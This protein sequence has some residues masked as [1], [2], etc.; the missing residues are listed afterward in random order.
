MICPVPGV[1]T[2]VLQGCP[3]SSEDRSETRSSH[4]SP[5]PSATLSRIFSSSFSCFSLADSFRAVGRVRKTVRR[6]QSLPKAT[7]PYRQPLP[8]LP[9]SL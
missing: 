1:N 3:D 4:H 2:Q 5:L 8:Y 7:W 6:F 9:P